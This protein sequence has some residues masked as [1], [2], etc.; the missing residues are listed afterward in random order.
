MSTEANKRRE[1]A[2]VQITRLLKQSRSLAGVSS[3][4]L[5]ASIENLDSTY[6]QF[7]NAQ[8]DVLAHTGE[9]SYAYEEEQGRPAEEAYYEA[10]QLLADALKSQLHSDNESKK[11]DN[12][13]G[14]ASITNPVPL[15][16]PTTQEQQMILLQ[17][18][19][20]TSQQ[21]VN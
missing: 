19:M 12:R 6:Q 9:A 13:G 18:Q 17:Q 3:L 14:A 5:Y 7:I 11:E 8:N 15:T 4:Q 20:L 10:K 16:N 1:L 2:L 21:Q